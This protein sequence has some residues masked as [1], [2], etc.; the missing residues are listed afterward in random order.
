MADPGIP[1]GGDNPKRVLTY[2][3]NLG[4]RPKSR[5]YR[6]K[7]ISSGKVKSQGRTHPNLTLSFYTLGIVEKFCPLNPPN[8][9]L[10]HANC[11]RLVVNLPILGGRGLL[12]GG[13][14]PLVPGAGVYLSMQ[15]GRRPLWT[16]FLTHAN[17]N[18]TLPQLRCGK[19]FP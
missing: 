5:F 4:T 1:R 9:I 11:K 17:E 2:D 8:Q 19:I 15:W 10:F 7:E 13:G 16:E 3:E 14:L 6:I 18:I 12:L